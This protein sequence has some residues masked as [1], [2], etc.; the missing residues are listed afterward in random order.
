MSFDASPLTIRVP[1]PYDLPKGRA[2]TIT[3]PVYRDGAQATASA[4]TCAIYNSAN[5]QITLANPATVPSGVPTLVIDAADFN[6]EAYDDNWRVEWSIT[7]DGD[8]H[9]SRHEAALVRSA[10][11]P[12]ITDDDLFRRHK[13]LDPNAAAGISRSVRSDYQDS[14][15]EA[16]TEIMLRLR[17]MGRRP[18]LI[19]SPSALRETHLFLTLSIVFSDFGG[20]QGLQYAEMAARYLQQ[21]E[22]AWGRMSFV[23]D[24][25]DD[26][27]AD[28]SE[29]VGGYPTIWLMDRRQ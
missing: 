13:M 21:Y 12:V 4:A 29:R 25:N 20:G 9:P 26:G 17:G 28:T 1:L 3:A 24:E 18:Y 10:L 2:H 22:A 14:I 11:H 19:L 8:P 6:D 15:D 23:Y 16:W 27:S 5:Q 7:V